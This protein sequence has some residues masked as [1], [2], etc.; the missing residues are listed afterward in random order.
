MSS[1]HQ[2]AAARA[3]LVVA[4]LRLV[5]P[6]RCLILSLALLR[7]LATQS[8]ASPPEFVIGCGDI[9]SVRLVQGLIQVSFTPEKSKELARLSRFNLI[10]RFTMPLPEEDIRMQGKNSTSISFAPPTK[11]NVA[12]FIKALTCGK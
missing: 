11:G 5:R 6:M 4:H 2:F 3:P 12:R 1:I 8:L 9:A 7:V 10:I